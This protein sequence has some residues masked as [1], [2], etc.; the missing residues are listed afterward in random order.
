LGAPDPRFYE[1][2]GPATLGELAGLIGGRLADPSRA[3]LAIAGVSILSRAGAGEISFC[4]ARKFAGELAASAASAC[5]VSE[6]LADAAPAGCAAV[7]TPIPHAAYALAAE[8]LHRPRRWDAAAPAIH[9]T[10]E[11]EDE[12]ILAQGVVIGAGAAIGRG[13][14]IGPN[15]VIGPGVAIGRDADI[16]AGV[17]IGFSLIGDRVRI[18]AGAVIGEAG[19]GATVGPSG[20]IDVPQLGRVI[21]QDGVTIGANTCVD[22]GAFDDTVIGENTKID[23]QVQIAHNVA[24]GRNCVLAAHTGISGSCVIGD[25]CQFGGRV[26]LADHINV[27]SGARLAAD[28]GVM[29]DVPAGETWAGSP[30]QPI[31]KYMREVAWVSKSAAPQRRGGEG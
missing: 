26:G 25:G 7:V 15:T 22:R 8:R 1:A 6:A 31:R 14:V 28:A 13:A 27:G 3:D 16:G 30:A 17:F 24:I 29:R 18:L 11:L 20:V 23:N 2:L 21:I 4:A 19:F 9:P 10:A 12:V 5:F